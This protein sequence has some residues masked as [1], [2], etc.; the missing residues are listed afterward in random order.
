MKNLFFSN[1][2]SIHSICYNFSF[3]ELL[4]TIIIIL[5]QTLLFFFHIV[6]IYD[7]KDHRSYYELKFLL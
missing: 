7:Q 2:N 3:K 1:V 4:T 6:N 5:V